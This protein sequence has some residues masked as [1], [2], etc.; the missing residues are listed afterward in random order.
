MKAVQE[1]EEH[2]K[3]EMTDLSMEIFEK[4]SDFTKVFGQLA[5]LQ[6]RDFLRQVIEKVVWDGETAHIYL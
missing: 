1:E 2:E 3:M 4:L 6:K 5:L